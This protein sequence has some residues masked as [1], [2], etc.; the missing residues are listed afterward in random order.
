MSRPPSRLAGRL[1]TREEVRHAPTIR[2]AGGMSRRPAVF[3]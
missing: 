2:I 1:A 3:S